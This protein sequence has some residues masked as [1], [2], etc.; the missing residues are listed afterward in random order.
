MKRILLSACLL[1]TAGSLYAQL[2]DT[3]VLYR[4]ILRQDSLLFQV[5][6]NTCNIPQF[7]RLLSDRFEFFHDRDSISD[8]KKFL[9]DVGSYLCKDTDAYQSKR[10]LTTG[11]IEIFP[12][13]KS[14]RLYGA[15]QHG[16]HRFY[17]R[18]AGQ[19][20]QLAGT[21]RFTHVWLLENGL[22]KLTR[23]L[24]YDHQDNHASPAKGP[25]WGDDSSVE[26]WLKAN[27]IP[28]LGVGVIHR[29]TLQQIRVWGE[30]TKGSAAPYNTI[31][32]V[33]SLT[34]PVTAIVA[35]KL[36]SQGKWSLDEPLF[37]YWT[38]PDVAKD[39][40]SRKLTTRH[41][42]SQQ[43]G[44]PNWRLLDS[45]KMLHFLRE[46]GTQ[47]GYS[48]EGM[49]YLREALEH[50][51]KKTLEQLARELIFAPTG[52]PD[53]R[54]TW[55][56][57]TDSTRF[58]T[59]YDQTGRPYKMFRNTRA[60]AADDLQTTIGDYGKFLLSVMKGEGLSEEV[61]R[62]M[63]K[64]QSTIKQDAYFGLGFVVYDLGNGRKA[65]S[66]GGADEGVQ[67]IFV[68]LPESG[69]G[70]VI[71]TNVDDGYKI[72]GSLLEHYLG[73]QGRKIVEI[74]TR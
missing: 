53:T 50:K 15:V 24:S 56:S 21:A 57:K 41:I 54:Y 39:P 58:A 45:N 40:R 8:K 7:E 70:L 48:G 65:L 19:T 29:G 59:G 27:G 20:E 26:D 30:H 67:T 33:A 73:D 63:G 49:E 6:F 42:L 12:L 17:E 62:E 61:F 66:H 52:M 71:F 23:A 1:L 68:L 60:N 43:S 18:I 25:E 35:L 22:W 55:N 14:D 38:D 5:G 64:E 72:Y 11:S 44:F 34:K 9:S 37:H 31:F 51:F 69:D 10:V 2:P 36:V 4:T 16:G 74:E 3:S 28:A 13:Y 46:P 47:Y 32:N